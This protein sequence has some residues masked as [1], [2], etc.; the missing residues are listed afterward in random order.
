MN[1]K[2][3]IHNQSIFLNCQNNKN[4]IYLKWLTL[5]RISKFLDL[6]Q[7]LLIILLIF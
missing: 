2:I 7:H 5:E 3:N 4:N 1:H 6:M